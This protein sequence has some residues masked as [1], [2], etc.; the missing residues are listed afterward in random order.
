MKFGD[1]L[2]VLLFLN[3][4]LSPTA[5]GL[6]VAWRFASA[7]ALPANF[8]AQSRSL[9]SSFVTVGSRHSLG[10]FDLFFIFVIPWCPSCANS[11]TRLRIDCGITILLLRKS[12]SPTVHNSSFTCMYACTSQF[13][14]SPVLTQFLIQFSSGSSADALSISLAV[15]AI[16]TLFSVTVLA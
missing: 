6:V 15:S 12:I 13:L 16:G 7:Y 3:N 8:L 14:Q 9:I 4:T 1:I 10:N 2:L 11:Y 5:T